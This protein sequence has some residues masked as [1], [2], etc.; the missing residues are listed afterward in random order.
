M[1]SDN[2]ALM[3]YAEYVEHW[4]ALSE[5][6]QLRFNTLANTYIKLGKP[7]EAAFALARKTMEEES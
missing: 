1:V 4:N 6:D 2:S 5:A 3:T 7:Q